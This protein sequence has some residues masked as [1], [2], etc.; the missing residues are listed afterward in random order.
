MGLVLNA[1]PDL[2]LIFKWMIDSF[3]PWC[4]LNLAVF[5]PLAILSNNCTYCNRDITPLVFVSI[6]S[7]L[8]CR[9]WSKCTLVQ[10]RR[11][12]TGRTAHTGSRGIALLFLDH[13]T[14]RGWV[15][16]VMPRPLITPR[17]DPVPTIQEAGWASGPVWTG[18]E[19]LAPTGIQSPDCPVCSQLLYRLCVDHDFQA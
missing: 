18:A 17:K 4:L 6:G 10:A 5:I 12:S 2:V 19:N 14:R 13:S 3:T 15:V 16:S 1:S 9:S 7:Q 11:L 8:A